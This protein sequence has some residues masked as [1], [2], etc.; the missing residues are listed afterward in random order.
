MMNKLLCTLVLPL[1]L[2][3]SACGGGNGGNPADLP[4][5]HSPVITDPGALSVP[6]F[7]SAVTKL[8][9]TSPDGNAFK[10]SLSGADAALFAISGD[11]SLRFAIPPD[12]QNPSDADKDN[13][14]QV[15]VVADDSYSKPS[16]LAL[17]VKVTACPTCHVANTSA[18]VTTDDTTFVAENVIASFEFPAQMQQ[19]TV[20]YTLTG[21]FATTTNWNNLEYSN[22]SLAPIAARIG[23]ASV[24]TCEIGGAGCDA[25]T[26]S[27]T[28]NNV[29][30]KKDSITFL[31]S[32]G[33]GGPDVGAQVLYTPPGSSTAQV[34]GTYNPNSC[35]DP[36]LKGDQHYV[37]FDTSGLIGE[38]VQIRIFDNA[39][40]GCGFV[41]FDHFYQTDKPRGVNAGVL[42]K[43]LS[44]VKVTVEGTVTFQKMVPF[45]SFEN[46]V[47]MVT[48]R[49][50][51]G[52]GA[53]ANPTATSWQGTTGTDAGAARVGDK[54][55]STCEIAGPG[56]PCDSPTG[57]L[58]SPAFKATDA[59]LNFLMHGGGAGKKV[60]MRVMDTVGNVLLSYSPDSCGPSFIQNDDDWTHI[61]I[62]A[63]T[64]A[65]IKA[66]LFDEET[67]G[68]GFVSTDQW[69]QSANAWN[70]SGN[71][72]DGGKVVLTTA[73]A[74]TLGFSV[75][76]T[77]DA[78]TQV[79]GDFD[80]A[81]ATAQVWTATGDFAN[82]ASADAWKGVSGGARV[83]ARAVSTCEMN[84][85]NKG[86]DASTG[87]LTSPLFTVD[88]NRP[89]LNFLMSGGNANG[90]VGLK[91]LDAAGN[92]LSTY[93]PNS[94]GQSSIQDDGSWV[95]VDLTAQVGKQARVQ[96]FDNES[97]GC[98]FV[99]F[100][101]VYMGAE[102][103]K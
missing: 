19:D 35:G 56:T 68:C 53:F 14:Y 51:T 75:S 82:P 18:H 63:L 23:D 1:V 32:G 3:V 60:G 4:Q 83:G 73:M 47:D 17:T 62:S 66:Q 5:S 16:T 26:G 7:T 50:W 2:L 99:S 20:K 92:V 21:A 22:A 25:P 91:V 13:S 36:V 88:A 38:T 57:T 67:S 87:T 41:A 54:A 6:E 34:L 71:G 93:T 78:F 49:G 72:K 28:I 9:V 42:S 59:Y 89:Y 102:R 39:S 65:F 77:A 101:H 80:D 45:A 30:I 44:P 31:M 69:Y 48:K 55:I 81:V 61:D 29:V 27:I 94:C 74:A 97:G 43:P 15:S 12:F 37:N 100:D 70:P 46:P 95:T 96:I 85:N 86:C 90:T 52:T 58:T 103:R 64:G 98:G 8:S 79:I 76:V 24:S 84:G 40:T 11:G 33:N 10:L